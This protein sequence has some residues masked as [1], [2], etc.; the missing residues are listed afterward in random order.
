[1]PDEQT[2][3]WQR[4]TQG[5]SGRLETDAVTGLA[6]R[7]GVRQGV[8]DAIWRGAASA[9]LPIEGNPGLMKSMDENALLRENAIAKGGIQPNR[10]ERLTSSAGRKGMRTAGKV[11]SRWVGPLVGAYRLGTE[12]P[13]AQG[14]GNQ[15]SKAT[16]IIGEET[17]NTSMIFAG[18]A[19]GTA[20]FPGAGTIVGGAIGIGL[21]MVLGG[22]GGWA[23][24]RAMDVAEAPIRG[25]SAGWNY[26]KQSGK[27]GTKL[28][29]GGRMSEG[30]RSNIAYTMRQRALS[31][32]NRSGINARSLLGMESAYLHR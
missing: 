9:W 22:A 24:N 13:Q 6:K 11:A 26:L 3:F 14:L 1:M 23:F 2:T 20:L 25:A 5:S 18:A 32:M 15:V 7:V 16:R 17:I 28:E 31:Q 8:G 27:Q 29:L 30:N 21:G 19:I 10:F 4:L 12:V